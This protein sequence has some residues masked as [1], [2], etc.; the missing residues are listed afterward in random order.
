VVKEKRNKTKKQLQQQF[1]SG[2]GS[3]YEIAAS[4]Y[5]NNKTSLTHT[6]LFLHLFGFWTR[7]LLWRLIIQRIQ[8]PES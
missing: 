3:S 1:Q 5:K 6:Q 4:K 7:L 8:R 2:I